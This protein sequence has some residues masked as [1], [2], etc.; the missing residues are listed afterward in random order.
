MKA[1]MAADPGQSSRSKPVMERVVASLL[2]WISEIR[3]AAKNLLPLRHPAPTESRAESVIAEARAAEAD[4]ESTDAKLTT[5]K[6][7]TTAPTADANVGPIAAN[8]IPDQQEVE[9]RREL[10]R[11]LFNDFWNGA[12]NKPV[13]F[14]QR[15]DEAEDY[16]NARLA[17]HGEFWRLDADTRAILGLPPRS[18]SPD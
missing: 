16:L 14:A 3:E 18:S 12:Y 5:P 9:R 4:T 17:A 2:G 8:G 13:A 1:G 10:V 11:M 15:L 7:F 6:S